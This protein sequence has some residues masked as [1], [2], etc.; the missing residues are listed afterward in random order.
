MFEVW[1]ADCEVVAKRGDLDAASTP[2]LG[3]KVRLGSGKKLY[4]R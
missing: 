3:R 4:C 1:T 2:F